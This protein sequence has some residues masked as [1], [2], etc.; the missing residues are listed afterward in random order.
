LTWLSMLYILN[1]LADD[2]SGARGIAVG[3][4]QISNFSFSIKLPTEYFS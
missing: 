4:N 1:V 3:K 2:F